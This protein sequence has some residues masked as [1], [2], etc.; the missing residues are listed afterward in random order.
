MRL[1]Q[2]GQ[3]RVRKQSPKGGKME[4]QLSPARTLKKLKMERIRER[5]S[6]RHYLSSPTIS[7][8]VLES[9]RTAHRSRFIMDNGAG[10]A[11]GQAGG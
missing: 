11:G 10:T 8:G 3:A 6:S 1:L 5:E 7:T 4:G 2:Q 9:A